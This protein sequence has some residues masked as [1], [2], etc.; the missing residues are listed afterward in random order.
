MRIT[1]ARRQEAWLPYTDQAISQCSDN[2]YKKPCFTAF[3][4]GD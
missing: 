4:Y 2:F 3:D 1:S